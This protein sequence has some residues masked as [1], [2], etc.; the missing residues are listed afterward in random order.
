MTVKARLAVETYRNLVNGEWTESLG[1]ETFDSV[2][3]ADTEDVVGRF[4]AS[5]PED[6]ERAVAAAERAF[7]TWKDVP[8]SRKAA[9]MFK[10]ADLLEARLETLA[11]ELT[12]EEGKT[13]LNSMAEVKR[14]VQTL[15]YYASE[16]MN[17]AGTTLPSDDPATFV[18]TKK[19]PLGVVAVITPWNFPLSIPVR[20]IAP[21]L[22]TGNTVVFKPASDTPLVA[23]R[24]AEAIHE[25]GF[26]PGVFNLVTGSASQ[27]GKPL[28]SHQ[29]VKAVTFTGSTA[30]GEQIQRTVSLSTRTQFEL[31]GKNPL[32]VLDDADIDFAVELAVKGGFEL[33]GQACT[34][35]SRVIV[36]EA[37]HDAFV[38]KL[39]ERTRTMTVGSG[40]D[41]ASEI[42]PLAN[43]SQLDNVLSYIRVGQDE[44]ADLAA[45]GE[46]LTGGDYDRGYYV[47]PAVFTGVNPKMRIAQEEIFGPVISV[48]KVKCFNK[49]LKVANGVQYGLSASICTASPERIQYFI[50]HMDSGLVKVNAPT[51]GNAV[52]APFGGLKMSGTG[53]YR[54]AGRAALDFYLREKTVYQQARPIKFCCSL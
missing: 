20:K 44:G 53:T 28:T 35:T 43:R 21:A 17:V 4:Q 13:L 27:A 12:R 18:Y 9:M 29:A 39:I 51:T 45:G 19:E 37:V 54:E 49:A 34:G 25:A 24:L 1:G 26:P 10:A 42:G 50:D 47:R 16:G 46:R 11:A 31:G 30:A 41:S 23:Y 15:R 40:F 6:V 36:M 5:V 48:I 8:P 38:E 14:S 22:V 3:P 7:R 32:I 2:N 52:N 33:T